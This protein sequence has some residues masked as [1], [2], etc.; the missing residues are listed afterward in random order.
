M[1]PYKLEPERLPMWQDYLCVSLVW[2][3]KSNH[4]LNFLKYKKCYTVKTPSVQPN[5]LRI[6]HEQPLLKALPAS[7]R[8]PSPVHSRI[9]V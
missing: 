2:D 7:S 9:R 8:R 1:E 4:G 5:A 3:V 6:T